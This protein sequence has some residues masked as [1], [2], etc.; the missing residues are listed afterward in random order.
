MRVALDATPLLGE[1]TGVGRH[2]AG[3]VY[4]LRHLPAPPD[5]TLA[6]VSW[7]RPGAGSVVGP[8]VGGRRVP[9]RALHL[10]WRHLAWPPVEWL[11]GPADVFHATNFVLPPTRRA[12]GVVTVHDLTFDR[13]PDL[14]TPAVARYRT[15]VPRSLARAAAVCVPSRAVADELRDRY[16][17]GS[18]PVVVT[19]NGV[20]AAWFRERGVTAGARRRFRLPERYVVAVGSLEPRKGFDVLLRAHAAWQAAD[21]DAPALVLVGPPGWGDPLGVPLAAAAA[22]GVHLT[23]WLHHSD[24]VTVVAGASALAFPSRYEGFGMPP[25]EAMATGV[26]VVV[27]DLPVLHE[28]CGP[29]ARFVAVGDV[30]G[31]VEALAAASADTDLAAE[32][33]RRDH[34]ATFSWERTARAA[35]EAYRAA[36]P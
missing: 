29:H 12:A 1:P 13:Y 5:L 15:L 31:L 3:L 8:P 16:R 14:V 24:L 11:S 9:A 20:D 23:G 30:D 17:V 25:L 2:V 10:A 18:T 6:A 28:V 27:S 7:R 36:R 19:P 21:S 32:Q 35:T 4:G 34:A 22:A 33:A 26:P